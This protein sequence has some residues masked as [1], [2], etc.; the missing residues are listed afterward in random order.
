MESDSFTVRWGSESRNW[1][2]FGAASILINFVFHVKCR[3][4]VPGTGKSGS[5]QLVTDFFYFLQAEM[6]IGRYGDDWV[7]EATAG[8]REKVGKE[9]RLFPPCLGHSVEF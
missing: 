1:S 8:K 9:M 7:I 6:K 3:S 4:K 2:R 5:C